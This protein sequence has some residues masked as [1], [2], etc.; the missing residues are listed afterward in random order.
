MTILHLLCRDSNAAPIPQT[1]ITMTTMGDGSK[2]SS[3]MDSQEQETV[4]DIISEFECDT[5]DII[6]GHKTLLKK[7]NTKFKQNS[8]NRPP[9]K[10]H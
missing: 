1:Q 10:N 7:K 5:I 2:I 4:K 6:S 3:N 9:G 8:K